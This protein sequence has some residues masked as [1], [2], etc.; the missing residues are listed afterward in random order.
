MNQKGNLWI[1]T[2]LYYPEETS[3]GYYLTRIAESLID[4]FNVKVI[5]GQPNYSA[6]GLRAKNFEVHN[7][8]EINRVKATTLNKNVI[9]YRLINMLTL[10]LSVFLSLFKKLNK[11]D[12]ILVVTTPPVLPLIAAAAALLRKSSYILLIH[13]NYPEILI[14]SGKVKENSVFV[15]INEHVNRWIYKYATKIIV[16]SRDMLELLQRKTEGLD[17]PITVIYNWAELENVKPLPKNK[18][19]LLADLR[20][21]D[22]F[23][24]LYA[25][26]MG[27][28][29]DLESI[30]ES[31]EILSISNQAIHFIF[32]G[33]GVKK[34]W[35]VKFCQEK[36]LENVTILAPQPRSRQNDFLN[37]CDIAFVSLIKKMR[38]VSMPS[39]TYN[40]L[41][42]GK[43][44]LALAEQNSEINLMIKENQVGWCIEPDNPV[45]LAQIII[46][47]YENRAGLKEM[48]LRSRAAAVSKYSQSKIMMEYRQ[49]LKNNKYASDNEM[50]NERLVK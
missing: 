42:A 23:I 47:I 43:P 28:P 18:N 17:V 11:G 16:V 44:I 7:N 41:A 6:K 5:C 27:Y 15:R 50:I 22:K 24:C 1:V 39:R 8:V 32:L 13:D 10:S 49:A 4:D 29:N 3:T 9:F 19:K 36:K 31:A 37:A 45:Q 2:E 21:E 26:N 48:G 38:G 35:L 25:G 40:I 33:S 20:L 30:V 34:K 14:A 46:N 12:K